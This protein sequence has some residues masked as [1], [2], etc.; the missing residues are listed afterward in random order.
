MESDLRTSDPVTFSDLVRATLAGSTEAY[1]TNHNDPY[2]V[3]L[4]KTSGYLAD[5]T[6]VGLTHHYYAEW[7]QVQGV[8]SS[9]YWR[10]DNCQ[11]SLRL[12]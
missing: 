1:S 3:L 7:R 11:F 6:R 5:M 2:E 4:R 8:Q 10:R 9:R 12:R